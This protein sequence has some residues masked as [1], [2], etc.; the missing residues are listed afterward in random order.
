MNKKILAVL[1]TSALITIPALA[2]TQPLPAT[3]QGS[4][5]DYIAFDGNSFPGSN[6]ICFNT[7]CGGSFQ[8][9]VYGPATTGASGKSVLT[10]VWCVDYQ[11]DVTTS[12]QYITNIMTLSD[13]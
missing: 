12:S 8:A 11:L 9:T 4:T 2:S 1:Y 7:G 10:T 5:T 6:L 13:I 3:F